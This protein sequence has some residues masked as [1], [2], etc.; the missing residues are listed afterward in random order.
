MTAR[1]RLICKGPPTPHLQQA[2]AADAVA[3]RN[4]RHSPHRHSPQSCHHSSPRHSPPPPPTGELTA[5]QQRIA[6]MIERKKL[7]HEVMGLVRYRSIDDRKVATRPWLETHGYTP[8]ARRPTPS[9]SLETA[10][11]R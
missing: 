10:S 7:H 3:S 1:L 9:S 4:G 6:K 5:R 8:I 11:R 2:V